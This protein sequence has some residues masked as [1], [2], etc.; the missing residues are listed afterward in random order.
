MSAELLITN[1]SQLVTV[2]GAAR[3]RVGAEMRD[4]GI[5][6]NGALLA[7]DGVIVAVGAVSEVEAQSGKDAVHIDARGSVVMPGFVDAHTH[8][9]FAGTRADEYELR[10]D[11]VTYQEI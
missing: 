7:R 9:V 1:S 2:A 5:F 11:G 8:P 4:L 3:A 6:E 10:A